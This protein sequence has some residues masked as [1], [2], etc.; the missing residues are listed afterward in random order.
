MDTNSIIGLVGALGI[1]GMIT[2]F[3]TYWCTIKKEYQARNFSEKKETYIGF[4]DAMH[5]SELEGT[6]EAAL[7][8]GY[9]RNRIELVGSNEV[10]RLCHRIEATNPINGNAHP[11]RPKVIL[12]LKNS[13]RKDLGI[14]K[15]VIVK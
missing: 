6:P 3:V 4:L 11:E 2:A 15:S 1:G 13:M 7:N 9:W 5:K 10:I 12:D 8:V 14:E